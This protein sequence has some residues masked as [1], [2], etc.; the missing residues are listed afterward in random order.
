MTR[1]EKIKQLRTKAHYLLSA[2]DD[3]EKEDKKAIIEE[4]IKSL[5]FNNLSE[6]THVLKNYVLDAILTD[7]TNNTFEQFSINLIGLY[8]EKAACLVLRNEE[9]FG[10]RFFEI[11][12]SLTFNTGYY[13]H[14]LYVG[15]NSNFTPFI[16]GPIDLL[17]LDWLSDDGVSLDF[18]QSLG[19]MIRLLHQ[20]GKLDFSH[21]VPTGK[22]SKDD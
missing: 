6:Y 12:A 20:V 8:E 18:S 15:L 4:K 19:S 13:T 10:R 11:N 17:G 21:F 5:G 22:E 9:I 16:T 14:A 1:N 2:A 3:L 7:P